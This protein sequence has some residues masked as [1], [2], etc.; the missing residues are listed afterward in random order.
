[1]GSDVLVVARDAP[2]GALE[3]ARGLVRRCERRWSRFLSDSELCRLNRS[4]GGPVVLPP[5]TFDL[6]LAAVEGWRATA[7]RFDPTILPALVATG[8]ART[9]ETIEHPRPGPFEPAPGCGAIELDPALRAVTLPPGVALDLG[10][11]GKGHTAD[12]VVASLAAEGATAAVADLGGD[13]RVVGDWTV[14]VAHPDGS[15]ARCVRLGDGAVATSSI[16]RRRW[17]D[18]SGAEH[19]HLIDPRCGASAASGLAQVT[20]VAGTAAWAEVLA[21]AALIAGLEE[22]RELVAGAGA[23]GLFVADDGAVC[24]LE[25]LEVFAA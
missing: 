20:V 9:F 5:E 21:K 10:G 3:R 6:V 14:G 2:A 8:Y 24:E 18:D 17:R 23:T 4:A 13:V 16:R 25:G 15:L 7:G 22:G 19:H 12:L 1:M 11:I